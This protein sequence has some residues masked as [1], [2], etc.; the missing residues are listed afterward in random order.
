MNENG[1]DPAAAAAGAGIGIGMLLFQLAISLLMI[2]SVWKVFSKAGQ[3]GWAVLIP[4]YNLYV[5]LKVAGKPGW[6]MA[7]ILLVPVANIIFAIMA[8]AAMAKNFGK[9][10]GFVVG[11]IFL[12]IIFYPILGFG[13]AQY[14]PVAS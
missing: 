2:I 14:Q 4:F 3:P 8:L 9:G 10:G 13:S 12:P 11:L 5:F 6:W 1:I 7:I